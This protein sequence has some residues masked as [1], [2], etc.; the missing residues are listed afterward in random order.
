MI[1]IHRLALAVLAA[2]VSALAAALVAQFGF[3][4]H[5]CELCLTQRVPFVIAGLLSALALA[6]APP[7][8]R[9]VLMAL[10]GLALLVNSGIAVFHVGVEQKWWQSRCAASEPVKLSVTDLSTLM[11][12]PAEARCDEPAW[13][14]HGLTMAG[15]NIVYS[16][17]L[18]LLVL[19]GLT[20]TRKVIR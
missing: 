7:R 4:L 8:L 1:T 20:R 10:A 6:L 11:R 14:W 16:G 17:G 12:Q 18:A 19:A 3:G 5:P 13:E 9:R 2:S 15:M